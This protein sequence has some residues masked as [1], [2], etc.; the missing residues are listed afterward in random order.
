MLLSLLGSIYN[1]NIT[2]AVVS[3]TD[4]GN[5]GKTVLNHLAFLSS[6]FTEGS[7]T[8]SSAL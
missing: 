3:D 4:H 6:S 1:R 5:K 8:F 7:V 2:G